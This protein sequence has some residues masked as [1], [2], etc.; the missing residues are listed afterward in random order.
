MTPRRSWVAL[1]FAP[2]ALAQMKVL[3]TVKFF[4]Q[5]RELTWFSGKAMNNQCP[6]CGSMA[7]PVYKW[8]DYSATRKNCT[9]VL[10]QAVVI[11]DAPPLLESEQLTRC[12]RCNCAF[13]QD[14]E[15]P[16]K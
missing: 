15:E 8:R 16:K 7:P 10:D 13:W 14:A 5:G 4:V 1:L 9:P 2:L 12:R 6:I 11:C 3:E